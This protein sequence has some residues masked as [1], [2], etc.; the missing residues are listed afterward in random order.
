M[1]C[2]FF[3]SAREHGEHWTSPVYCCRSNI[4]AIV[5]AVL[6]SA[7]KYCMRIE[8]FR[9]KAI[10][11]FILYSMSSAYFNPPL[12]YIYYT[13][14]AHMAFPLH[15]HIYVYRMCVRIERTHIFFGATPRIRA[16]NLIHILCSLC[17]RCNECHAMMIII[18]ITETTKSRDTKRLRPVDSASDD[19]ANGHG[20]SS[21]FFMFMENL[22][23]RLGRCGNVWARLTNR[24]LHS[25]C[26]RAR[27]PRLT[28]KTTMATNT[29]THI[30]GWA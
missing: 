20:S 9:E 17:N 21:D 15:S 29:H 26:T 1:A 8:R 6:P 10:H 30:Y 11:V 4:S 5:I 27:E 19:T 28:S 13:R 16:S 18:I 22:F 25:N 12:S 2:D 14:T 7:H 24:A 23:K 3:P